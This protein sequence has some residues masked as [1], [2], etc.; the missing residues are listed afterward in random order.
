MQKMRK[1]M[2]SK[3]SMMQEGME[4]ERNSSTSCI[5]KDTQPLT[6]A[7][8]TTKTYTPWNSSNS[9][10]VRPLQVDER[11]KEMKE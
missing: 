3:T 4:K 11:Y 8:S 1:N 6:I 2:R 5:G 9:S 10:T 7:G